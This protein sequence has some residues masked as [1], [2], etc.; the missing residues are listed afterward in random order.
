[1][2]GVPSCLTIIIG[3]QYGIIWRIS[4]LNYSGVRIHRHGKRSAKKKDGGSSPASRQSN[5]GNK[6]AIGAMEA[7]I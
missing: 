6:R 7:E 1:M 5:L 3:T 2:G 4:S